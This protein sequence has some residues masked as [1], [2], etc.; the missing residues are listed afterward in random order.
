MGVTIRTSPML[1][2]VTGSKLRK[3]SGNA[4]DDEGVE[5]A[6]REAVELVLAHR[7]RALPPRGHLC[8][9]NAART[10]MLCGRAPTDTALMMV[11]A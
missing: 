7:N 1:G 2:F 8:D 4:E 3:W 10:P 5:P 11:K 9:N 6:V